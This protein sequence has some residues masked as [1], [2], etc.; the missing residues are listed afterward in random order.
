M[1]YQP[2]PRAGRSPCL[3]MPG[4]ALPLPSSLTYPT[5]PP[6]VASPR[7]IQFCC[8]GHPLRLKLCTANRRVPGGCFAA[9]SGRRRRLPKGGRGCAQSRSRPLS[10]PRRLAGQ[11]VSRSAGGAIPQE[12]QNCTSVARGQVWS[13][14]CPWGAANT[15]VLCNS[16][17]VGQGATCLGPND[18]A[19]LERTAADCKRRKFAL[20]L[21]RENHLSNST[22]LV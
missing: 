15:L 8:V 18:S 6:T 9:A 16:Y 21:L 4:P 22:L 14:P 1:L 5:C 11:W 13:N 10:H 2:V 7:P 17:T 3:A 20:A 19:T 12:K